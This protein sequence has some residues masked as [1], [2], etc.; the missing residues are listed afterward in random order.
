MTFLT[1]IY[2]LSFEGIIPFVKDYSIL[3]EFDTIYWN[4]TNRIA[5]SHTIMNSQMYDHLR[6]SSFKGLKI[7]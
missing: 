3:D 2:H 1:F 7:A 4:Y 5:I 6:P